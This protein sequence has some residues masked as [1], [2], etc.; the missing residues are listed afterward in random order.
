[1]LSINGHGAPI[2]GVLVFKLLIDRRPLM[3]TTIKELNTHL[4][5]SPKGA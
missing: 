3:E 1:M 5:A 2:F 4:D